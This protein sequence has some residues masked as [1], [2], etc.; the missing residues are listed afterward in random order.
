DRRIAQAWPPRQPSDRR[1]FRNPGGRRSRTRHAR[2]RYW[3]ASRRPAAGATQCRAG[4][5]RRWRVNGRGGGA[6][7]DDQRSRPG[8]VASRAGSPFPEIQDGGLVKTDDLIRPLA[9]DSATRPMPLRRAF[10]VAMIPGVVI[11]LSL[12]LAILGPRPHIVGLLTEPR[13]AFKLCLT[14]LLVALSAN[15]V[16]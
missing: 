7:F 16:M 13:F 12:Y 5:C 2:F 10:L 8:G 14:F 6:P 3:P 9:A 1:F 4:H 15:L 11:A